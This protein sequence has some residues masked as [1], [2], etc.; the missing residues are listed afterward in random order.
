MLDRIRRQLKG[1][2]PFSRWAA[3]RE[4]RPNVDV[5]AVRIDRHLG[6]LLLSML[7]QPVGPDADVHERRKD[8]DSDDEQR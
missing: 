8:G 5:G 1:I 3:Q 4:V 7:D 6:T 2:C